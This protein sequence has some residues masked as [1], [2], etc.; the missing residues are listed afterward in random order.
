MVLFR[1]AVEETEAFYLGDQPAIRKA[2]PKAKLR[3]MK[4]YVQVGEPTG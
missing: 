3:R 4:S 2:F 1:I